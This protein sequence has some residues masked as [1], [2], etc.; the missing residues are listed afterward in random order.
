MIEGPYSGLKVVDCTRVLA[1]P[2]CA[3]FLADQGATV[4]KVEVPGQ[5]DDSRHIGPFINGKSAYF[6][7]LNRGKHSIALDLKAPA[8]R[9]VFERLLGEADVLI[10]NYR[11]GTMEKLGYDWPSLHE[12]F[13]RLIYTAISGFGHTGPYSD[14]PAYDIVV[15]ASD[16][17]LSA[18]RAV[19][20]TVTN[21]NEAPSITSGSTTTTPKNVSTSTPVYTA[22][23]TDPDA[24]TVLTY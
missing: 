13:P 15:Q 8:D 11:G 7:G 3:M 22:T 2:Y 5:G 21:F 10:E 17:Y 12:R 23:A 14:K 20:I 16:G 4:I 6:M 19:A 1:G 18:T 9:E 24:H